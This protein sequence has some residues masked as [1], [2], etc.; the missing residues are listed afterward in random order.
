M[1][2]CCSF[3][4]AKKN[5]VTP[6]TN[7]DHRSVCFLSVLLEAS[8]SGGEPRKTPGLSIDP[9]EAL[10]KRVPQRT[11]TSQQKAMTIFTNPPGKG[12]RRQSGG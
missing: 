9:V 8:G 3:L 11:A 10:G 1:A 4:S 12:D 5:R 6:P 2:S 7:D